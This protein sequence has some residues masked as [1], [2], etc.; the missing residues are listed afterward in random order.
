MRSAV[1]RQVRRRGGAA[2]P[3]HRRHRGDAGRDRHRDLHHPGAVRGRGAMG[4]ERARA[5]AAGRR[6][7]GRGERVSAARPPWMVAFVAAAVTAG[8]AVGPNYRRPPVTLPDQFYGEQ[9]AAEARSLADVPW[10]DLFQDPV[11][12]SLVDEALKKGFDA[13]LAAARVEE[14]RALYG[15]ARS[16]FF[17]AAD[18]QFGWQRTRPDQLQ[19]PSGETETRWTA[20][21]GFTWE[22]DLWGR[23]RRLNEAAKAQYLATEEG[24]RGVLLSL[25]SDVAVAY[26]ELRELDDE[27]EIA[28]HTT[29]AF[30]DTY[31]LFNRRL[32]GGA[33][34]ALETSR[35][36]GSRGQV[37]I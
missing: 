8:C 11:L 28:K 33:A 23:I 17:P 35:A 31:D 21:V 12:K 10:W 14:A 16:E 32:E 30:Q 20:N 18:Y 22:L 2:D 13:R 27:L 1:D 26:L 9:A 7:A 5:P 36:E 25:V 19:N 29:A 6:A 3:R 37:E 34:S 4:R 24:R 15:I